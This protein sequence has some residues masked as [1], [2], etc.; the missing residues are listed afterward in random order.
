LRGNKRKTSVHQ[1]FVHAKQTRTEKNRARTDGRGEKIGCARGKKRFEERPPISPRNSPF[2]AVP[3]PV[4]RENKA[5]QV[6]GS[7]HLGGL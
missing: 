1:S 2:G 7:K 3:E 6:A 5:A 4:G